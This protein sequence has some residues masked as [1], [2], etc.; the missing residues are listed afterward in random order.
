VSQAPRSSANDRRSR[1]VLADETCLSERASPT[2][3][4]RKVWTSPVDA[5]TAGD[6]LGLVRELKPDLAIVD[7]R[8]A[9]DRTDLDSSRRFRS[10]PNAHNP[11]S[12][13]TYGDNRDEGAIRERGRP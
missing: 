5:G 10:S 3:S 1:V 13:C 7:V 2:R 9:E 4:N 11:E 6:L 12:Q 8:M